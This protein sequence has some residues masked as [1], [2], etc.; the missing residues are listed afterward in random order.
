MPQLLQ[1]ADNLVTFVTKFGFKVRNLETGLLAF[2]YID[3]EKRANLDDIPSTSDQ[4]WYTSK[5][6]TG[7]TD[8][9]SM[10]SEDT[11]FT[12]TNSLPETPDKSGKTFSKLIEMSLFRKYRTLVVSHYREITFKFVFILRQL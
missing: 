3:V 4:N 10:S 8:T 1:N 6:I 9:Q 12:D 2:E 5:I 11:N 7:D